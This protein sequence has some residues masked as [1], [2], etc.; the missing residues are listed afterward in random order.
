MRHR[1][2]GW[3]CFNFEAAA[4]KRVAQD[5]TVPTVVSAYFM[6]AAV[7]FFPLS[8]QIHIMQFLRKKGDKKGKAVHR[9]GSSAGSTKASTGSSHDSASN[10]R[11][12]PT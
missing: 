3:K 10:G 7:L 12:D 2:L 11:F 1:S 6:G 5:L 9:A 4:N 8:T